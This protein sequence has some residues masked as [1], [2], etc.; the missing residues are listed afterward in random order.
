MLFNSSRSIRRPENVLDFTQ[1]YI[2]NYL[3]WGS[4]IKNF[5]ISL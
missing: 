3:E 1:D 5:I 4:L 2:K